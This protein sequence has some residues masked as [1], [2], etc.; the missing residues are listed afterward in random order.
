MPEA[1]GG[2]APSAPPCEVRDLGRAGYREAWGV[3]LEYVRARKQGAVCDQL[4]F[5]EHP[6]TITLGRN[7]DAAHILEDPRRLR[8]LGHSSRGDRPRRRCDLPRSRGRLWRIPSW[9]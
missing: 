4:L 1:L 2:P 6:P 9:T 5:V 8:S 3:Q 7:A